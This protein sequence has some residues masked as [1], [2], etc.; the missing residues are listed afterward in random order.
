ML[1]SA[2]FISSMAISGKERGSRFISIVSILAE[3][4]V[5][6][7]HPRRPPHNRHEE[8]RQEQKKRRENADGE[9]H[10]FSASS[11]LAIASPALHI[12]MRG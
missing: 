8:E 7:E 1:L 5:F 6:Q 9:E 12:G 4:V 11:A 10:H 3:R 2:F